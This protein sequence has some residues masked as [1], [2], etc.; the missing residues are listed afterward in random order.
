M[1][2]LEL[3]ITTETELS[4]KH[5]IKWLGYNTV[6]Q[7]NVYQFPISDMRIPQ[8]KEAFVV[9]DHAQL[10]TG[11]FLRVGKANG[12]LERYVKLL[13]QQKDYHQVPKKTPLFGDLDILFQVSRS[14]LQLEAAFF[15]EDVFASYTRDD[16]LQLLRWGYLY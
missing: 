7:G 13:E 12:V 15:S 9:F 5:A 1:S 11:V 8:A 2:G 10:L 3:G 4:E 16:P 6:T 14:Q